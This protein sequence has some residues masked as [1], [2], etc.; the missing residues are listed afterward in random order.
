MSDPNKLNFGAD[1]PVIEVEMSADDL[2]ALSP[3]R[4]IEKREPGA[5]PLA[6]APPMTKEAVAARAQPAQPLHTHST[7][8]SLDR[9]SSA[10]RVALPMSILVG[11]VTAGIVIYMSVTPDRPDRAS[12]TTMLQRVTERE[13]SAAT[14]EPEPEPEG[15]PVRFANPFDENEVFEFPPGTSNGEVRDAVADMLMKRAMERQAMR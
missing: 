5:T 4:A 15:E 12:S 2:L 13:W 9:R 14:P 1:E 6:A 11:A 8:P 7:P 3:S 10:S